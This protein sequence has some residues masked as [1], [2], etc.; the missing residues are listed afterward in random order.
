M[1]SD[2]APQPPQFVGGSRRAP[3]SPA[4]LSQSLGVGAHVRQ[5]D[6]DVLLALV[7]QV[8][9]RGQRQARRDDALDPGDTEKLVRPIESSFIHTHTQHL[10]SWVH[11]TSSG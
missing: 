1:N 9:R 3:P 7:G 2:T 8:L 4:Y 11:T 5:D 6:Q 10:H